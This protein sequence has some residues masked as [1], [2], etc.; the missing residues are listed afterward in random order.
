MEGEFAIDE[1]KLKLR[2]FYMTRVINKNGVKDFVQVGIWN[3]NYEYL[4]LEELKRLR[5]FVNET[6]IK[7]TFKNTQQ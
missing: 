5:K 3:N 4:D 1:E 2:S 6:I 7:M